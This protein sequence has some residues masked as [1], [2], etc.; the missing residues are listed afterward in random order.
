MI[1]RK[2]TLWFLCSAIVA[3]LAFVLPF[4]FKNTTSLNSYNINIRDF[5]AQTD[6]WLMLFFGAIVLV[7]LVSIFLFKKRGLQIT[8]SVLGIIL[9]LGAFAYEIFFSTKEGNTITFG[10]ANSVIYIGLIIPLISMV[11][12]YMAMRGVKRDI[13]LLAETD[14]LR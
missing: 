5:N 6:T 7:N 4:G 10:I 8:T 14:R 13:K 3:G 1:Q 9:G 2:Q 12:T 11:L